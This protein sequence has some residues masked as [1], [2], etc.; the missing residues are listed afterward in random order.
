MTDIM[1]MHNDTHRYVSLMCS[2]QSETQY[3][4]Q[5]DI[6]VMF[7]E[8]TLRYAVKLLNVYTTELIAS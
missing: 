8:S 2:V 1:H 6:V 3:Y 5:Q 7:C 4:Q